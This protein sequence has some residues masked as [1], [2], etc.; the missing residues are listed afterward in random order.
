[1]LEN[2]MA[3]P[4][5]SRKVRSCDICEDAEPFATLVDVDA[6]W[7]GNQ[8][9]RVCMFCAGRL[10]NLEAD[11]ESEADAAHEKTSAAG[12]PCKPPVSDGHAQS[13][14]DVGASVEVL[15]CP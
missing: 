6:T 2:A 13:G 5:L 1:M 15:K 8:V 7:R 12:A 14:A 3:L 4:D 11:N 9:K 10:A